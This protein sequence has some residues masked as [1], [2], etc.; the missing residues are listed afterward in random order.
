MI[1]VHLSIN[2]SP[3]VRAADSSAD[4]Q[5]ESEPLAGLSIL[6]WPWLATL[7]CLSVPVPSVSLVNAVPGNS[8]LPTNE[9]DEQLHVLSELTIPL[10]MQMSRPRRMGDED[11]GKVMKGM[12]GDGRARTLAKCFNLQ[13][14]AVRRCSEL[15]RLLH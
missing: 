7:R 9:L 1:G 14:H 4:R 12:W 3:S 5:C 2:A 10:S 13:R 6:H 8:W 11:N 15:V